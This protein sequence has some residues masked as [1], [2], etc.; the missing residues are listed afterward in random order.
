MG[1]PVSN[2]GILVFQVAKG[3]LF[4]LLC[5]FVMNTGLKLINEAD[6][7]KFYIGVAITLAPLA[8]LGHAALRLYNQ[9]VG[10]P[11]T[12]DN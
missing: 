8:I 10:K 12:E 2:P 1:N 4:V 5:L 9:L 7:I 3:V 11:P 6:D